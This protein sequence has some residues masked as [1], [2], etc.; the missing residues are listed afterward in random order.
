MARYEVNTKVCTYGNRENFHSETINLP[1][2]GQTIYGDA[3]F[4]WD[5]DIVPY[6]MHSVVMHAVPADA[7]VTYHEINVFGHNSGEDAAKNFF[8]IS[9]CYYLSEDV[10]TGSSGLSHHQYLS[11]E[12]FDSPSLNQQHFH[13]F[14]DAVNAPN[15][16]RFRFLGYAEDNYAT[17][18]KAY[19]APYV[20][21]S[22]HF[23]YMSLRDR[24]YLD[25]VSGNCP[26]T[27]YLAF[28]I[29]GRNAVVDRPIVFTS[30]LEWFV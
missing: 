1:L 3:E 9:N 28:K 11:I 10:Y 27:F 15:G 2:V 25:N 29:Y 5:P 6:E 21:T 22:Q 17:T 13:K 7:H 12:A 30:N 16:P 24:F 14:P 19:S 4:T 20:Y 23:Q 18:P 8:L 26:D